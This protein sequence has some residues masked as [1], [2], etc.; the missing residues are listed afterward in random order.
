MLVHAKY[1]YI[2]FVN[3]SL[4]IF[5]PQTHEV[6][7]RSPFDKELENSKGGDKT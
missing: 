6:R 1:G 3:F 2:R 7:L 4:D 5:L